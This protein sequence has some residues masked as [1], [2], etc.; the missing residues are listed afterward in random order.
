MKNYLKYPCALFFCLLF[1]TTASA[2]NLT[3]CACVT[4]TV[5]MLEEAKSLGFDVEQMNSLEEKYKERMAR[6]ERLSEGKSTDERSEMERAMKDCPAYSRIEILTEEMLNKLM[7]NIGEELDIDD[8]SSNDNEE[9]IHHLVRF[10]QN[11]VKVQN[12]Q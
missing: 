12:F 5:E 11:L 2:Q 1:L 6:C 8:N 7:E 9:L 10:Q 3:I 4:I